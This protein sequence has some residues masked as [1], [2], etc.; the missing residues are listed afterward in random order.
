M[1]P[2]TG[3]PVTARLRLLATTDLHA[4]LLPYDYYA[5]RPRPA[6]GLAQAARLIRQ[7]RAEMP[8]GACLLLDNGDFLTGGLLSDL[9][10]ARFKV[11]A[12]DAAEGRRPAHPM[13]MA[14]NVLGYDA[15][16]LGNHEFDHGLAFLRAALAEAGFPVLSANLKPADGLPLAQPS[17]LIARRV[18]GSDGT[19]H[20]ITVGVLGLTPPQV[21]AWNALVMGGGMATRDILDAARDEIPRLRAAGADLVVALCHSGIGC[22]IPEPGME[23]AA[24]PVAALPGLDAL[25]VGHTHRTFPDRGW[26]RSEG[27]DPIAGTLHGRPAVQPGFFGSHVGVMDLDLTRDADGWRIGRHA[28]R[29]VPV[30]PETPPDDGVAASSAEAHRILHA[31]A[32]WP[33]G[34]SEV[35]LQSYFSLVAADA[36]LDVVADAKRSEARRLLRGRPEADLPILCAVAPFKSGGRGGP[37]N[38]IDIPAGPLAL[39][40]AADLYIHPNTLCLIEVTGAQVRDWLERSLSQFST[41][42]PGV[43]DQPLL[44]P[45]FPSYNFD[46]IDGASWAVDASQPPRTDAEGRILDRS[47]SR[48]RDLRHD[49]RPVADSDRFLLATNSYRLGAGGGFGAVEGARVVLRSAILMRDIVLAHLRTVS[50]APQPRP[51]WRFA[52][53]PGTAAWFDSGPGAARHIE[54]AQDRAIEPIGPGEPGFHRYRLHL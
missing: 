16:A 4:H 22:A 14:M 10:A 47:A 41:L 20:D 30:P 34:A 49:G 29:L 9:L 40:Q 53:L 48:V 15:A 54:A 3:G 42:R 32:Q 36:T 17:T 18:P 11:L 27:V 13:V 51:R 46:V 43:M 2:G 44:D 24:L 5:D 38:Y 25:V 33:V 45:A 7:L 31:F 8:E 12:P 28:V 35:P 37:T 50:L 23:N 19:W 1:R 39:R 26:P 52:P 21:A 6:T